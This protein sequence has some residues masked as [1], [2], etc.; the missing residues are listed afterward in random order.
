[1]SFFFNFLY[2]WLLLGIIAIILIYLRKDKKQIF[3]DIQ[4]M[5]AKHNILY[6]FFTMMVLYIVFPITLPYSI[7]YFLCKKK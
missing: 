7:S 6:G 5:L 4:I 3:D 1:M 2:V